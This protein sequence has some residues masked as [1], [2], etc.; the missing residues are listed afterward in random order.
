[1]SHSE[2]QQIGCTTIEI[3]KVRTGCRS[4]GQRSAKRSAHQPS[5]WSNHVLISKQHHIDTKFQRIKRHLFIT[6]TPDGEQSQTLLRHTATGW[7]TVEPPAV[8]QTRCELI[9]KEKH[10]RDVEDKREHSCRV[11]TTITNTKKLGIHR[12]KKQTLLIF[13]LMQEPHSLLY[14]DGVWWHETPPVKHKR[15]T[16]L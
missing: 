10:P 8:S 2:Q 6:E 11:Q 4:K 14:R 3:N 13:R 7:L 15:T 9:M 16:V 1:M 12:N 5:L